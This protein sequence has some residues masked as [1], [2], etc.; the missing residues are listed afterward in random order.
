MKK[1]AVKIYYLLNKRFNKLKALY[2]L[3][4][5]RHVF[6]GF[7]YPDKKFYL[8][9]SFNATSGIFTNFTVFLKHLRFAIENGLIPVIDMQYEENCLYHE[10]NQVG[11]INIW[12]NYFKQPYSYN[13][14]DIFFSTNVLFSSNK[15]LD[16]YE[17]GHDIYKHKKEVSYWGKLANDYF[18]FNEN[19]E[20]YLNNIYEGL[21]PKGKKV[22]GVS[23]REGYINGKPLGHPIQP[24]IKELIFDTHKYFNELK[25]DYIFLSV[26]NE[27]VVDLF[28]EEFGNRLLV[29]NRPRV[30]SNFKISNTRSVEQDMYYR[31]RIKNCIEPDKLTDLNL[32]LDTISF[33]RKD[34]KLLKGLEY[35][36]EMYILSKSNSLICGITSGTIS[37]IIL[38]QNKYEFLKAYDLGVY[39]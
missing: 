16:L 21:V 18:R 36:S 4:K 22:L 35:I 23:V 6:L 3:K 12:E 29:V 17:I 28:K 20:L 7:N 24:S 2:D 32:Y 10:T 19:T 26:E 27:K 34:D 13:L 5:Q 11:K 1:K 31:K 9:R 38:N 33:E 30:S 37:A 15:V 25:Y 39:K 8:I 14:N